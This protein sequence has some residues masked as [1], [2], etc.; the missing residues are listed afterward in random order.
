MTEFIIV[1][2]KVQ[3][4]VLYT[5]YYLRELRKTF[6][7]LLRSLNVGTVHNNWSLLVFNLTLFY[8]KIRMR[9]KSFRNLNMVIRIQD[10]TKDAQN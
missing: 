4:L 2:R 1:Y 9:N 3:Y 5:V 10:G 8:C 7:V 6:E